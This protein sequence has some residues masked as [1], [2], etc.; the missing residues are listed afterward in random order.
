MANAFNIRHVKLTGM[1][2]DSYGLVSFGVGLASRR[3]RRRKTDDNRQAGMAVFELDGRPMQVGY[4][5]DKA[6]PKAAAGRRPAV[7]EPVEPLKYLFAFLGRHGFLDLGASRAR[8][9]PLL[10]HWIKMRTPRPLN[11]RSMVE[12]AGMT[13]ARPGLGRRLDRMRRKRSNGF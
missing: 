7:V 2:L 5:S 9:M 6:K 11:A 13:V 4:G 10:A 3:F 1:S 8:P 12:Q